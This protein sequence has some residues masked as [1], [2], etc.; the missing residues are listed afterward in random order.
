MYMRC[1]VFI[2]PAALSKLQPYRL[3]CN[4]NC[5]ALLPSWTTRPMNVLFWMHNRVLC[6]RGKKVVIF[7]FLFWWV[8]F[9]FSFLITA[10]EERPRT[11]RD[12]RTL[13]ERARRPC[14][15]THTPPPPA[16]VLHRCK[17]LIK[18]LWRDP[19]GIWWAGRPS[20]VWSAQTSSSRHVWSRS[21]TFHW[22]C[23]SSSSL[24]SDVR[25]HAG[26]PHSSSSRI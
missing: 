2:P 21:V 24:G 12:V 8:C 22:L 14:C 18:H 25:P 3:C 4:K 1:E 26:R 7:V 15:E 9:V 17:Q 19:E 20:S 13:G 11:D 16:T 10:S 6:R 23:T 5:F